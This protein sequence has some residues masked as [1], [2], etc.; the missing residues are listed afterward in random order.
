MRIGMSYREGHLTFKIPDVYSILTLRTDIRKKNIAPGRHYDVSKRF[1]SGNIP[2]L[3]PMSLSTIMLL[4]LSP[5]D[6]LSSSDTL[7]QHDIQRLEAGKAG[8]TG[9]AV[10]YRRHQRQLSLSETLD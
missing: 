6:T 9:K 10:R 4:L 1:S 2:P 5:R 3:A 8:K 7:V